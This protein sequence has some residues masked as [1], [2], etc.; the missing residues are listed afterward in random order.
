MRL[1]EQRDE[2]FD[3]LLARLGLLDRTG[4]GGGNT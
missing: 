3:H 1:V 4:L 2:A